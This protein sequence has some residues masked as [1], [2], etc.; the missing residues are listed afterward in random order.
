MRLVVNLMKFGFK[1]RYH[2]SKLFDV[3]DP[4]TITKNEIDD[5]WRKIS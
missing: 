4:W 2:K 1:D 5:D 3:K